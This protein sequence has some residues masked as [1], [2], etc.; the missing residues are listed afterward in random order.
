MMW[1]LIVITAH[2]STAATQSSLAD[3]DRNIARI[4]TDGVEQAYCKSA[5][6]Q[7]VVWF[8][9]DGKRMIDSGAFIGSE[10]KSDVQATPILCL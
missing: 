4:E 1:V 2:G 9:K 7:D 6:T 10:G 8:I 3:C 5:A